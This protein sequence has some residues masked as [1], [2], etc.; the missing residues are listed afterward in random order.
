MQ[1]QRV[2][3]FGFDFMAAP[4]VAT[5]AARIM[6]DAAAGFGGRPRFLITPNAYTLVHYLEPAHQDLHRH[7]ARS[8]YILPDGMPVVW[9][10]KLMGRGV[11]PARLTGSDLFPELWSRLKQQSYPVSLVLPTEHAAGLFRSD[12]NKA[13]T[14][15]PAMFS[16]D[17]DAYIQNFAASVADG[18]IANG[19]RFLF[20]GLNFPK[21][22]KMGIR[23]AEELERR[24]YGQ[25]VLIL[26]LGASFEFYFG[27]KKRAPAFFRKT[28][29]E[30][31]H[32]FSTEPRRLWKRYTV[33]NVRFLAL[34]W[35][36][37]RQKGT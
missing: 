3:L 27:L 36:E 37:W 24:G 2:T 23:I 14:S 8:A 1:T 25:G 17:D 28:G 7:Y 31:L 11:L 32:R 35:R 20:L 22:E 6:D 30:W 13:Y 29:L 18:I 34:A 12:Y 4:D 5:V 21:Q 16:A 19:S 26:L 9:M 10:S 33:D 15:V